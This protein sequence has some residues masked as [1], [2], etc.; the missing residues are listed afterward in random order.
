MAVIPKIPQ[1][2]TSLMKTCSKCGGT[3]MEDE[4]AKTHSP[5]YAD[6]HIPFCNDCA[7][8]FLKEEDYSWDS[9]DRLCQYCGIP[10]IVKEWVRLEELNGV[11]HTW[12]TYANVFGNDCYR[13]FGWGD[14]N[15]QYVKLR[16]SKLI[17]KEVPLVNEQHLRELQRKWG[18]NYDEEELNYLEDLYSGLLLTQNV[19]GALQ[20]DQ[21][22]KICK[23]SLVVDSKIRAGD[24][25][26]EKFLS[27]Y[28]KLVKTAEF[29]PKNTKNAVD[30]DSFAEVGYW[31]EKRGKQNKFYDGVTRDV[32]DETIKNIE[33]Y[34]QRLYINEGGIGDSI[35]ERIEQLKNNNETEK[36][37]FS[38][39]LE[40]N[41]DLDEYDNAGFN[42]ETTDE[43]VVEVEEN[44]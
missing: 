37:N 27:S 24:K 4:F 28:D 21:A 26:V 35:N 43:F 17:E 32:I 22:Q 7:N 20:I 5:F 8:A 11:E 1:T 13:G 36:E 42:F 18:A 12:A 9:I 29:K 25:D 14:Y 16:E 38:Y 40:D 23:L 19:N 30:F 6:G 3:Y 34:N 44:G 33:N 31:L 10:F 41:Y 15:K 39:G 2:K